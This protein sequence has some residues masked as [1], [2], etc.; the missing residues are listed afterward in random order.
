MIRVKVICVGKLKE[1][2]F[3]SA[4][5]EYKKRLGAFA[6]L[7]ICELAEDTREGNL[8]REA[9]KIRAEIPAGSYVIALCVEGKLLSSQEL[10]QRIEKVKSEG[11]SKIC[12]IIGSSDG[13]DE[14]IKN[15]ADLKLSMSKMTF[16]HHLARV[17]VLE[18]IY[19]AMSIA[20]GTKYHK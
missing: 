11:K 17:M 2:F 18:Q 6:E 1:V 15:Q 4:C 13:M 3:E 8:A 7:E 20:A 14:S 12:F 5:A 9:E 10:S 19:R 16:P